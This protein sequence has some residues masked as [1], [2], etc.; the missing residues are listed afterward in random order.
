MFAVL[1]FDGQGK[2]DLGRFE[3]QQLAL[4]SSTIGAAF[5]VSDPGNKVVNAVDRFVAHGGSWTP[6]LQIKRRIEQAAFGQL[7]CRSV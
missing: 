3:R 1:E 7:A 5:A 6:T 2:F 4:A